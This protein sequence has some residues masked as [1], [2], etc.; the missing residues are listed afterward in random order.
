ML[1]Y[2]RKETQ[3]RR[4][5][6]NTWADVSSFPL[7]VNYSSFIYLFFFFYFIFF[8]FWQL[9]MFRRDKT[10]VYAELYFIM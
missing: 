1:L 8:F 4:K 7:D 5:D 10:L 9:K 2:E 3:M 6:K